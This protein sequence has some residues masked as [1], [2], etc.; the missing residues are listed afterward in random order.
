MNQWNSLPL[1]LFLLGVAAALAEPPSLEN[2][3][4]F[5]KGMTVM[6]AEKQTL[7]VRLR[8]DPLPDEGQGG[9]VKELQLGPPLDLWILG[10]D[11]NRLA[12]KEAQLIDPEGAPV[13]AAIAGHWRVDRPMV[14]YYDLE[15]RSP[16][17][18]WRLWSAFHPFMLRLDK[19]IDIHVATPPA[20][21]FLYP[22]HRRLDLA[23]TGPGVIGDDERATWVAFLPWDLF[24]PSR[25]DIRIEGNTILAPDEPLA[26][27]AIVTDPELSWNN[28]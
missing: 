26:L 21:L 23:T 16:P 20:A 1:A 13:P 2:P 27:K 22:S 6:F 28:F 25:P 19:P 9:A 4:R 14:G 12:A 5:A 8:S 10:V 18:S 24:E 15:V 11:G 7:H 17:A 3:E